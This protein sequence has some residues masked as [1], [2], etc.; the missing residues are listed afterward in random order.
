MLKY[1]EDKGIENGN[2]KV[3]NFFDALDTNNDGKVSFEEFSVGYIVAKHQN[4]IDFLPQMSQ[5]IVAV[6]EAKNKM[7]IEEG[8]KV[9][10]SLK[11]CDEDCP[12]INDLPYSL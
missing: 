9:S 8:K 10:I 7:E 2:E 4:L 11:I 5:S 12:N 3:K 1:M 6:K